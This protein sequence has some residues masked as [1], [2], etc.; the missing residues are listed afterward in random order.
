MGEGETLPG[1]LEYAVSSDCAY[2]AELMRQ[3]RVAFMNG[4]RLTFFPHVVAESDEEAIAVIVLLKMMGY[5]PE[6]LYKRDMNSG[7]FI[8]LWRDKTQ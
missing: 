6:T 1:V 2:E 3:V 4:I 7:N 5:K 8:V